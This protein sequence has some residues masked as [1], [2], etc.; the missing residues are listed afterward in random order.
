[1]SDGGGRSRWL[2]SLWV[3]VTVLWLVLVGTLEKGRWDEY[4]S[5][6]AAS[7]AQRGCEYLDAPSW[8]ADS[9]A[10]TSPANAS[11]FD[12]RRPSFSGSIA[13]GLLLPAVLLII[14]LLC[15]L[16]FRDRGDLSERS[17]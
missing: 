17:S 6:L 16:V 3:L 14:G 9:T 15:D 1:V 2:L 7:R 13:F 11:P 4:R 12:P 8:C 5:E 10:A